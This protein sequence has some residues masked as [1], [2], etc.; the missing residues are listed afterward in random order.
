VEGIIEFRRGATRKT[1]KASAVENFATGDRELI[2]KLKKLN[3]HVRQI[4]ALKKR[5]NVITAA[6][7]LCIISLGIV[8]L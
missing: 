6:F 8:Y 1:N 7:Y 3:N 2:G 4:V 5:A